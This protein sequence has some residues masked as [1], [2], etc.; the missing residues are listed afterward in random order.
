[1]LRNYLLIALRNL[2]RQPGYTVINVVGLGVG[3]GA[4]LLIGLFVWQERTYDRFHDHADR[5]SRVWIAEEYGEGDSAREFL[6]LSS[7]LILGPTVAAA[8]PDLEAVVR[9]LGTSMLVGSEGHRFE[10]PIHAVDPSFFDVFSFRLLSGDP[11]NALAAPRQVVLTPETAERYFPGQD[12]VGQIL[13]ISAEMQTQDYLVTGIVEAPPV[14]SSLQFRFLIPLADWEALVGEERRTHWLSMSLQTYVLSRPETL[15]SDLEAQFLRVIDP[16]LPAGARG[17]YVP[18][19]QPVT[20]LRLGTTL[21]DRVAPVRYRQYL[22]LLE[23]IAAFVL[24]V[25]AIN[26]V[27]LS[28]GQST[29]R[30]REVGLR[31]VLGARRTQIAG[32]F[33]GEALVLAALGLALGVGLAALYAPAFGELAGV[34]LAFGVSVRVGVLLLVLLAVVGL[35][36]GAY[37]AY[38]L[39]GFQPMEALKDRL[40]MTGDRSFLRRGLVVVQFSLA[41][42]LIIG[43][44]MVGRQLDY[45][46]SL[47]LGFEKAHTVVIP[48][49]LPAEPA[50]AL[51]ERFSHQLAG[52][53][54]IEDVTLS[55]FT[56]S[57]PWADIGYEDTEGVWRSYRMNWGAPDF[58]AVSGV[59]LAAGRFPDA[60]LATDSSRVVVNEA[61]I[62]AHGWPSPEE[63]VGR[64][65]PLPG[66]TRFELVGVVRDFHFASLRETVEP[67]VYTLAP[68]PLI[69]A[70]SDFSTSASSLRKLHVRISDGDVPATLAVLRQGWEAVASD[71][72]FDYYFLDEAVD[73][74]YRQDEQLARIA[75]TAASLALAIAALGLFALATLTVARRRKEVGVRKVLGATVPG[76]VALLSKD[77]LKLVGVA[78]VVAV[79]VGYLATSRWLET[80]AYRVEL[81]PA[82]FVAAGLLAVMV[83]LVAVGYHAFRAATADPVRSLRSE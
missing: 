4:C 20:D 80:F 18:H 57:E 49:G 61:L 40:Q 66:E 76:L 39:A 68:N 46:R 59:T 28:L 25:A 72:P 54:A 13:P 41:I 65:L 9:V 56:L 10:E 24:A 48:T 30:G 64:A 83:A 58:L 70:A 36:A 6:S 5:I 69:R 32:Q 15:R 60:G 14:V 81:G 79:P 62:R 29:R 33:W 82:V 27:T 22:G 52:H 75:T 3:M 23:I 50:H 55:A 21:P 42:L 37:P 8:V 17:R 47:P 43:T 11:A 51:L 74:R 38:V 12:P 44:L 78:F 71:L 19:L 67:M 63:A 7:P 1:M 35:G 73:A 31:K 16:L 77:F 45:V 26:F 2:R 34:P 53:A